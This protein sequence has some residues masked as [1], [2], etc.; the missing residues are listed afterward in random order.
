MAKT[1]VAPIKC[2][3]IP[4]LELSGA[5]VMARLLN[6]VSG[7]LSIPT[8]NVFAWTDSHV[9]LGWPAWRSATFQN[10]CWKSSVGN[11]RSNFPEC[12]A[13]RRKQGQ[14]SGLCL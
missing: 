8:G 6:Y 13:S 3:T 1:K 14:S 10:I 4:R 11:P 2:M 7:I 12:M 5:L 9:V